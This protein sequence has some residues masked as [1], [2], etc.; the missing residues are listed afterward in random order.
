MN[1]TFEQISCSDAARMIGTTKCTVNYWCRKGFVNYTDVSSPKSSAPRYVLTEE[2]VERIK[3]AIK[4]YGKYKWHKHYKKNSYNEVKPKS[5]D[6]RDTV[7]VPTPEEEKT[8]NLEVSE[9][10]SK[11]S[12]ILNTIK[13]IQDIKTRLVDLENEKRTLEQELEALRKEVLEF[14]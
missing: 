13:Y 9:F 3:K 1:P 2:E 12:E 11:S 7:S 8:I 10:D 4:K 14:I 5:T 6:S